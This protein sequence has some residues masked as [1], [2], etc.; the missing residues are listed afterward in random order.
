MVVQKAQTVNPACQRS[1]DKRVDACYHLLAADIARSYATGWPGMRLGAALLRRG[2]MIICNGQVALPGHTH[3]LQLDIRVEEGRILELGTGL[4]G[5]DDVLD[6][7]GL[8]VLP[9]AIDP[10]VHMNDPGYTDRESFDAGTRAAASGGVTTVI[11]M[12]CTSIPPVTDVASLERKLSAIRGEAVVDYGLFGGISAQSFTEAVS[13][14]IDALAPHVLGFKCYLI[15]GMASFGRLDHYQLAR[16][17]QVARQMGR[18]VLVHA[19]D[20]DY[21]QSAT[22]YAMQ[23]GALP[24]HYARSRPEIAEVLAVLAAV[25]LAEDVGADLHVVHV[26]TGVAAEVLAEHGVTGETAPHY[27]EF[28]LADFLRLGAPLKVTPPVKPAPNREQLWDHLARGTLAFVASDHAPCPAADK[29]TGSIWTDYSGIPGTGTLLPYMLSE[30][31]LKG[32]IGLTRF[33]DVISGAAARRYGL[34]DRKGAIALGRDADLALVDLHATWTVRGAASPSKGK[35]TPLEG[36]ELRGRLVKT[37]VRGR[38][39]YDADHGV[40]APAGYGQLLRAAH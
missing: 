14:E 34:A 6:A 38:V 3:P 32:R 28:D 18:P 10:H 1:I 33:L 35:V 7:S 24:E 36:K 19:E 39:V 21:V 12:P 25:C 37:L 9:G 17:F 15:S 31:Y 2:S 27:L 30:G 20:Y 11:D 29:A 8:L 22:E 5:D 40:V 16:V 4:V 23:R 13:H 26:S